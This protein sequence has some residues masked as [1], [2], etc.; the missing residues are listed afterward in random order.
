M[1]EKSADFIRSTCKINGKALI[2]GLFFV[3]GLIIAIIF[4]CFA[5][6]ADL[7]GAGF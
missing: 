1:P 4:N 5:V 3:L 6:S 2:G 7:N